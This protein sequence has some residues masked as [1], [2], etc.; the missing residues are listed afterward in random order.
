MNTWTSFVKIWTVSNCEFNANFVTFWGLYHLLFAL[1]T[2]EVS[3]HLMA[4]IW[5]K[6]QI[7]FGVK[8]EFGLLLSYYNCKQ[9]LNNR[10][11][12]FYHFNYI[13]ASC[14]VCSVLVKKS[15]KILKTNVD[16]SYYKDFNK[17]STID[18][19]EQK[20]EKKSRFPHCV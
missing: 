14:S 13:R 9:W 2:V 11:R 7:N 15:T 5:G 3:N 6:S 18:T 1:E 4:N 17:T 16:K 8:F 12:K 20:N 19:F 10:F